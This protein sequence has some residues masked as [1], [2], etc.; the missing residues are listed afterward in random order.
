[1]RSPL[2][3]ILAA[4]GVVAVILVAALIGDRDNRG[5]TVPAGE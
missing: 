4:V 5:E 2:A 3:W 1:M